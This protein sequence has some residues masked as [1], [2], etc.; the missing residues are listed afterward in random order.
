[1]E[2]DVVRSDAPSREGVVAV[3]AA[4]D[5]AEVPHARLREPLDIVAHLELQHD[6]R[7]VLDANGGLGQI[8]R[9]TAHL[10][11]EYLVLHVQKVRQVFQRGL[12]REGLSL[13]AEFALCARLEPPEV[14]EA[15]SRCAKSWR[16][17]A[18]Y[19]FVTTPR[20]LGSSHSW[21]RPPGPPQPGHTSASASAISIAEW[22]DLL[23]QIRV[24]S[25]RR[26]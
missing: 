25:F 12:I 24:R 1:M 4:D 18:T 11:E 13:L 20:L 15:P 22:M 3:E 9:C 6:G 5:G 16:S 8:L 23:G 14:L 2:Y 19:F 7:D 17:S 10:E 21:K 26:R